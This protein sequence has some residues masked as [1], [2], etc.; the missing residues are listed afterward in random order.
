MLLQRNSG[1]PWWLSHHN[2][3]ALLNSIWCIDLTSISFLAHIH[4]AVDPKL[5]PACLLCYGFPGLDNVICLTHEDQFFTSAIGCTIWEWNSCSRIS[6]A[7]WLLVISSASM[8]TGCMRMFSTD[9][10]HTHMNWDCCSYSE[11]AHAFFAK[12]VQG[13]Y[14]HFNQ[15]SHF[16]I[17]N[18]IHIAAASHYQ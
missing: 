18:L 2:V 9:G 1:T 17:Y 10:Y 15:N 14:M 6:L 4:P 5:L 12:L 8:C 7:T 3:Y 16:E 11:G 13:M